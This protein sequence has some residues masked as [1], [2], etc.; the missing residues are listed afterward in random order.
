MKNLLLHYPIIVVYIII[1]VCGFTSTIKAQ[2]SLNYNLMTVNESPEN[3]W[4]N[5]IRLDD[6]AI[7][8]NL[9][10]NNM[11]DDTTYAEWINIDP[12]TAIKVGDS[13]HKLFD[14]YDVALSPN[15]TYFNRPNQ[16]ISFNLLFPRLELEKKS[17]SLI[18]NDSSD[19]HFKGIKLYRLTDNNSSTFYA[20]HQVA[21]ILGTYS[22]SLMQKGLFEEVININQKALN[23][24][25]KNNIENADKLKA[26]AAYYLAGSYNNLKND[27]A[28]IKYSHMV[29]QSYHDNHWLDNI[30]L[31]RM[32]GVLADAYFRND[33]VAKAIKAGEEALRI[34]KKIYPNGSADLAL[35]YEKL[36]AY[37]NKI[38][39][40][41]KASTYANEYYRMSVDD[42]E[43]STNDTIAFILDKCDDYFLTSLDYFEIRDFENAKKCISMALELWDK[44]NLPHNEIYANYIN[45]KAAYLGGLHDYKQAIITALS[46]WDIMQS[47]DKDNPDYLAYLNNLAEWHLDIDDVNEGVKYANMAMSIAENHANIDYWQHVHALHNLAQYGRFS[48]NYGN[49]IKCSQ[50]AL[51]LLKENNDDDNRYIS[52]I[53]Y[54]LAT[55]YGLIGNYSLA[56]KYGELSLKNRKDS[57]SNILYANQLLEMSS[58]YQELNIL[59]KALEYGNNAIFIYLSEKGKGI[60]YARAIHTLAMTHHLL[61]NDSIRNAYWQEAYLIRKE[62]LDDNDP[63]LASSLLDMSQIYMENSDYYRCEIF[64][65]Q[66]LAIFEST[67]GKYGRGYIVTLEN[68]IICLAINNKFNEAKTLLKECVNI[69]QKS[70]MNNFSDLSSYN[71]NNFWNIQ[72]AAF[73]RM[74]YVTTCLQYDEDPEIACLAYN[75][76][77]LSKGTL[78]SSQTTIDNAIR[79]NLNPELNHQINILQ[80]LRNKVN[81]DNISLSNDSIIKR[82][83][84]LERKLIESAS[85]TNG[86]K[87]PFEYTWKDIQNSLKEGELAI[88]FYKSYTNYEAVLLKKEWEY[89]IKIELAKNQLIDSLPL[90]G[91]SLYEDI[92]AKLA[93]NLIFSKI[94]DYTKPNDII[95]YSPS[96]ALHQINLEYL[97]DTNGLYLTDEYSFYRL[98]STRQLTNRKSVELFTI[99]KAVLYGGLLYDVE[100]QE[101]ISNS[102]EYSHK[103]ESSLFQ[104]IELDS[105]YRAGWKALPE[106]LYEVTDISKLLMSKGIKSIVYTG[107]I[108]NEESFKNLSNSKNDI[109]HLATHGFFFK[110]QEHLSRLPTGDEVKLDNNSLNQSGIILSAAQRVWQGDIIPSNIEDGVLFAEEIAP[111]NL[112]NTNLVI[113]SAC[114]TALGTIN[115]DGVWG[116]QRAFKLAGVNS[117]LM[118]LWKVDDLSTRIL[119]TEFYRNYLSGKSKQK[120]LQLAQKYI[121]EYVDDNGIKIFAN[122]SYWASWILL[123]ALY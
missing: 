116:L 27:S 58:Y 40:L 7:V 95:Y 39:D 45:F 104:E 81:G 42:S 80:N 33:E 2:E 113:L 107:A 26:S 48:G 61:K 1:V 121:R 98:S 4:I 76:A 88:E 5:Y 106:T 73:E 51:E 52:K 115:N 108:G 14:A 47:M 68:L 31:A 91:H 23:D 82:I 122:P 74:F 17:F 118:S 15:Y 44:N 120:S 99:E 100:I 16:T 119:M 59:D 94:K 30:A 62:M 101:M 29:I 56:I 75:I 32:Y 38:K 77:L 84:N 53:L 109:I 85:N 34:K 110:D 102:K 111:L 65:K 19:W 60:D 70:T 20:P 50:K 8:I 43:K 37:Y 18:E 21:R 13:M 83:D 78:L 63:E 36:V 6:S 46:V 89:P 71:R 3:T 87:W 49:A 25:D 117:I 90:K 54:E 67:E 28:S 69:L 96:G 72:N 11:I 22:D 92:G 41:E 93:F 97:L 123:D 10:V 57:K 24:I 55:N 35:T 64:L 86:F 114:Q 103:Y 112:S 79:D 66:A 105:V 12:N 9:S